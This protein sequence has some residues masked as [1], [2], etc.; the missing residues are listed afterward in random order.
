MYSFLGHKN[1]D[2]GFVQPLVTSAFFPYQTL[3]YLS[4][5]NYNFHFGLSTSAWWCECDGHHVQKSAHPTVTD[6]DP[7]PSYYSHLNCSFVDLALS[8]TC[9]MRGK[10][11]MDSDKTQC[12][13]SNLWLKFTFF[14]INFSGEYPYIYIG[15]RWAECRE[16]FKNHWF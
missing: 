1:G 16:N 4:Y 6:N 14:W 5:R 12:S 9:Q 11:M 3:L 15:L 8:K 7:S 2:R 10:W 13:K